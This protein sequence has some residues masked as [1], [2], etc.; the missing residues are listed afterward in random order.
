MV[1]PSR[2]VRAFPCRLRTA[3]H[4][5]RTGRRPG[6]AAAA[7]DG[8]L[9]GWAR[10]GVL[11]LNTVLTVR[12][13]EAHSHRNRGWER[14]VDAMLRAVASRRQAVFVLWGKPAQGKRRLLG[15]AP[16]VESAH[17]SPLS[18]YRGFFGSKPFSR[19]NALLEAR[20]A[21]PVDWS[22]AGVVS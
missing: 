11:L 18:S 8:C 16:V 6:S 9:A 17:P 1:W 14:L 5:P 15:D 19:V 7:P 10:Q 12:A 3:E 21:P 13:G 4:L 2:C 20:G 22:A